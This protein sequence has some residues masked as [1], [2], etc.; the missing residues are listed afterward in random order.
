M[1]CTNSKE[2]K[3]NWNIKIGGPRH[4]MVKSVANLVFCR[5]D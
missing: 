1:V 2:H 3:V 4:K 5:G